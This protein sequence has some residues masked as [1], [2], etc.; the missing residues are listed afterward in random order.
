[1]KKDVII[2]FFFPFT[3]VA[4]IQHPPTPPSKLIQCQHS[5]LHNGTCGFQIMQEG[6]ASVTPFDK[7]EYRYL[8]ENLTHFEFPR[9][10]YP[11][12]P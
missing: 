2:H 5:S 3:Q 7:E 4:S 9:S 6:K 10:Y 1:M 8:I 12:Y 11:L